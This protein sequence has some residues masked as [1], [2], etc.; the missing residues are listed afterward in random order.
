MFY[1]IVNPVAGRG[2]FAKQ[3]AKL[4]AHL[5]EFGLEGEFAKTI[6]A[7]DGIHLAHVALKKGYEKVVCVGGDGTVN[8]VINGL[9]GED[10]RLG[11]IPWGKHNTIAQALGLPLDWRDAAKVLLSEEEKLVDLGILG[12]RLFVAVAGLGVRSDATEG[13]SFNVRLKIDESWVLQS[14]V[15]NV[16]FVNLAWRSAAKVRALE[17]RPDDELFEV[18]ISSLNSDMEPSY[19]RAGQVEISSSDFV[20]VHLDYEVLRMSVPFKIEMA[21]VKQRLIVL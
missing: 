6:N 13:E 8:E 1:F 15:S 12:Q 9:A 17:I 21:E 14:N 4:K 10:V 16:S 19:F 11:I 20:P 18:F 7:G 3:E 5:A 2:D